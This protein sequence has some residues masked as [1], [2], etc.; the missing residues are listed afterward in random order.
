VFDVDEVQVLFTRRNV[1][2]EVAAAR[3]RLDRCGVGFLIA[4]T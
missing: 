2:E 4:L 1:I 3:I